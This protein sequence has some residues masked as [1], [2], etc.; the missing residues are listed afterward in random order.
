METDVSGVGLGAALLQTK[1]GTSCPRD[2]APEIN[3]LRWIAFM[4]KNVS[5]R[6]KIQ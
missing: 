1:E 5:S 6:M 2:N 4:S 3:I